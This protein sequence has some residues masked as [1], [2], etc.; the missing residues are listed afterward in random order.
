ITSSLNAILATLLAAVWSVPVYPTAYGT[1][2]NLYFATFGTA[3]LFRYLDTGRRRWIFWAGVCTGLSFLAKIFSLYFLAA[4]G[5]FLVFDE[6]RENAESAIRPKVSWS[7][8]SVFMTLALLAFTG[9]LM[10]LINSAGWGAG[11]MIFLPPYY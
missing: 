1:W 11:L 4:A 8:Y 7:A 3:A 10:K 5:L 2:Y 9:A 6:Q